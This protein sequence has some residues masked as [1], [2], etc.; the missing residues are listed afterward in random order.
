M[1]L[2]SHFFLPEAVSSIKSQNVFLNIEKNRV[3]IEARE[4][5]E[6]KYADAMLGLVAEFSEK[7]FVEG[8]QLISPMRGV[9]HTGYAQTQ[10][11]GLLVFDAMDYN[12]N[13]LPKNFGGMSGAG[14]W[15]V[16]TNDDEDDPTITKIMLC[17]IASFQKDA[18]KIACQGWDRIDQGLI[19]KIRENLK[20]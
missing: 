2:H 6:R 3:K 19:P 5:A 18:R 4:P 20:I 15:R 11:N 12:L 1:I 14:V 13:E 10:E 9:L 16:Y 7:S 8:K 17:G